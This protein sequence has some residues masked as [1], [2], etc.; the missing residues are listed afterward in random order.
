MRTKPLAREIRHD[1][2]LHCIELLRPHAD[3][4]RERDD[5][6]QAVRLLGCL[7]PRVATLGAARDYTEAREYDAAIAAAR[8][9]FAPYIGY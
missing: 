2:Q 7:D 6:P 1:V 4:H 9:V 8:A 3:G 5:R